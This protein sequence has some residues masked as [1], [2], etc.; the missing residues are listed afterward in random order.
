MNGYI[1][2]TVFGAVI[3]HLLWSNAWLNHTQVCK[4]ERK[5]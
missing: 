4:G 2:G 1:V 5:K 3:V